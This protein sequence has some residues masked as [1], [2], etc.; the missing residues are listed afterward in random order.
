MHQFKGNLSYD[1]GKLQQNPYPHWRDAYRYYQQALKFLTAP[2]LR[3]RLLE[4]LQDTIKV[5]RAL[6]KTSEVQALLAEGTDLLGR[7]L[8]ETPSDGYKILLSQK[9]AS[10]DYHSVVRNGRK[11]RSL[12]HSVLS[13]LAHCHDH[14]RLGSS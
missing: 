13:L 8:Q 4:V 11:T 12:F 5:C 3:Q 1:E 9:F 7:L 6:D 2:N 10:F 14:S